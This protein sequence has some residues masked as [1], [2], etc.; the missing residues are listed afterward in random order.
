MYLR[1]WSK[2][3]INLSSFQ[4]E[5]NLL[6]DFATPQETL[7]QVAETLLA[8]GGSMEFGWVADV[9]INHQAQ[10]R[11]GQENPLATIEIVKR[12]KEGAL[13]ELS[14]DLYFTPNS[15]QEGANYLSALEIIGFLGNSTKE[16]EKVLLF[17]NNPPNAD[18]FLQ[19]VET[20]GHILHLVTL[21]PEL[22]HEVLSF[23]T[24][25]LHNPTYNYRLVIQRLI[26]LYV[27]HDC[28]EVLDILAEEYKNNEDINQQ[29]Y[30]LLKT[31]EAH[32]GLA[33][34]RALFISKALSFLTKHA[35][36]ADTIEDYDGLQDNLDEWD[37]LNT[38]GL[39]VEENQSNPELMNEHIEALLS[40]QIEESEEILIQLLGSVQVD[41]MIKKIILDQFFN[42]TIYYTFSD[43]FKKSESIIKKW[44]NEPDG[45]TLGASELWESYSKAS[46]RIA[47]QNQK[48]EKHRATGYWWD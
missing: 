27:K 17:L 1:H 21:S 33:K 9:F 47:T 11:W 46:N 3:D 32:Y 44:L 40:I 36:R 8:K 15:N 5:L 4:A 10:T 43:L 14:T 25:Q 13:I 24:E 38:L 2:K 48:H 37:N 6:I 34:V 7:T 29:C 30:L 45:S 31:T 22:K 35:S 28:D 26:S 20:L 39:K 12:L 42:S 41:N 18:V 16:L 19:A 23:Y